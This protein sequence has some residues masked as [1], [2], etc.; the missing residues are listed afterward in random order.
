MKTR[1]KVIVYD[2]TLRDGS[3]TEGISFSLQDKIAIAFKLDDLGV[4]Y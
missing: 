3:Q 1:E 2:T 4:L